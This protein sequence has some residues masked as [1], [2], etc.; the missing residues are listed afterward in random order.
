MPSSREGLFFPTY[1]P[2]VDLEK[3]QVLWPCSYLLG[4]HRPALAGTFPLL[5]DRAGLLGSTVCLWREGMRV[6][7]RVRGDCGLEGAL[8]GHLQSAGGQAA[9]ESDLLAEL[10]GLWPSRA[11]CGLCTQP[12]LF[13]CVWS[14]FVLFLS[15]PHSGS[16]V[17]SCLCRAQGQG[18]SLACVGGLMGN[19]WT[20]LVLPHDLRIRQLGVIACLCRAVWSVLSVY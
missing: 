3:R 11:E 14:L 8:A 10:R 12:S 6:H 20:G 9:W 4:E 1:H 7:M 19:A 18:A 13:Y 15:V 17:T 5:W 2:V 16:L